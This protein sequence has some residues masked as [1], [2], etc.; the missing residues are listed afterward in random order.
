MGSIKKKL[1]K[2]FFGNVEELYKVFQE[3][4]L[5]GVAKK[6]FKVPYGVA[7]FNSKKKFSLIDK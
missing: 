5:T 4:G 3:E 1:T 2:T 6:I 7:E